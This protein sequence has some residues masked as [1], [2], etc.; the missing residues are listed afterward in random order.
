MAVNV[1]FNRGKGGGAGP[2]DY[3]LGKD[4]QREMARLLRGDPEQ[5]IEL[6]DSLKFA[7]NYTSGCL[8]FEEP[9]IPEE[10]KQQLMDGLENTL[11]PGLDRDQYS[12]M[13]VEHRDK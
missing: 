2:V 4:R 3:L 1:V 10:H 9:D 12:V 8:S 11:L 6:I 13:W 7:Q 5:M